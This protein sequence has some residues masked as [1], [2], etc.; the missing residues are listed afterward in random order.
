MYYHSLHRLRN[1]SPPS[2]RQAVPLPVNH[3]ISKPSRDNGT[4][5]TIVPFN[6]LDQHT[7]RHVNQVSD[8]QSIR[9]G[10]IA[11]NLSY[12]SVDD[13]PEFRLS[14]Q[15]LAAVVMKK[16][17][18]VITVELIQ[19]NLDQQLRTPVFVKSRMLSYFDNPS[20]VCSRF[21][22]FKPRCGGY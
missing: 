3:L 7:T 18:I 16:D 6:M 10:I 20:P 11:R 8:I 17:G 5:G 21:R 1:P 9:V 22:N 15:F 13:F 2:P 12:D 19:L 4:L 14:T